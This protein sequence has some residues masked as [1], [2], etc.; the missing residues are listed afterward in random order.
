MTDNR[1]TEQ[2]A[3]PRL[4]PAVGGQHAA[5][6]PPAAVPPGSAHVEP[7][8]PAEAT[9]ATEFSQG[10]DTVWTAQQWRRF[11]TKISLIPMVVIPVLLGVIYFSFIAADRFAVETKFSIRQVSGVAST[12]LLGSLT[13]VSASGS[14]ITDSYILIDFI[15]SRELIDKLQGRINLHAIYSHEDADFLT[16]F[17]PDETIEEFREYLEGM[18]TVYFDSSSQIITME[19]Q[20]FTPQDAKLVSEEILRLSEDLVNELSEKARGDTLKNAQVEVARM[21]DRLR[22]NRTEIRKFRD[23]EQDIDPTK[24]AETQIGF[25]S[26]IEASLSTA[27]AEL[28]NLLRFMD[29]DAPSVKVLKSKIKAL[30]DQAAGERARLGV[31]RG[32]G[33]DGGTETLSARLEGYEVLAL[34]QEFSQKAYISALSSLE[35]A[36]VEAD[37][38]QRYLAAFV[39]P[40]VPQDSLY[41]ERVLGI[42]ITILAAFVLWGISVMSVYIV[43]EHAK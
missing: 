28:A 32:D 24:T 33:K 22:K 4:R 40:S 7:L 42:V 18:I 1:G 27:K 25:L 43:R 9:Y 20:A 38:Q 31:D 11:W 36:R 16:A 8:Q 10:L 39:R 17:D 37:R 26:T 13:G 2:R 15:E 35:H 5:A 30:E 41:P 29:A 6:R 14:T 3:E 12:D 23:V 34:E 19:V 21:E